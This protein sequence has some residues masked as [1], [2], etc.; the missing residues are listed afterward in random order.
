MNAIWIIPAKHGGGCWFGAVQLLGVQEVWSA[1]CN[2]VVT[3]AHFSHC[4]TADL[5][6]AFRVILSVTQV[7][8]QKRMSVP[9]G[10]V[11]LARDARR[12]I[13][14][15][16]RQPHIAQRFSS[17]LSHVQHCHKLWAFY[18]LRGLLFSWIKAD[19]LKLYNTARFFERSREW[20]PRTN[21][22]D[23][24]FLIHQWSV[25]Q[26]SGWSVCV[27]FSGISE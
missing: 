19:A 18:L 2:R 22:N 10:S 12:I 1:C 3:Q 5:L 15:C 25:A 20:I 27:K 21:T 26:T 24:S 4:R 7:I 13:S 11:K 16:S 23:I 9:T 6:P 17:S 8:W 14:V